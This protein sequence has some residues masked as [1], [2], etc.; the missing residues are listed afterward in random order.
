[1][2]FH[3][4]KLASFNYDEYQTTTVTTTFG[5]RDWAMSVQLFIRYTVIVSY[6]NT[7]SGKKNSKEIVFEIRL[8]IN[9]RTIFL[10]RFKKINN[11]IDCDSETKVG[12]PNELLLGQPKVCILKSDIC[13][14][15]VH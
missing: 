8:K 14:H 13:V 5:L 4:Q 10:A 2:K 7:S 3:S 11:L 1:M 6:S 15:N 12:E 9:P